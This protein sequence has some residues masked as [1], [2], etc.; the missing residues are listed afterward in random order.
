MQ[1]LPLLV[2]LLPGSWPRATAPRE[3]FEHSDRASTRE[4]Q[5]RK[6]LTLRNGTG[7]ESFSSQL[8]AVCVD[9][10]IRLSLRRRH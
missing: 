4:G 9:Q 8:G 10:G 5:L 2:P 6:K 7:A 1:G 3:L